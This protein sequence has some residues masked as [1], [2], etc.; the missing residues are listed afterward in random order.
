MKERERPQR[1]TFVCANEQANSPLAKA[2]FEKF[3]EQKGLTHKFEVCSAGIDNSDSGQVILNSDHV[4]GMYSSV[5]KDLQTL[6]TKTNSP[7]VVHPTT[8]FR[9]Y[10][11][12]PEELLVR[13]SR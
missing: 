3:L 8:I 4:I 10:K 1:I 11:N 6:V 12:W 7:I 5:E 9:N 13:Q 2:H